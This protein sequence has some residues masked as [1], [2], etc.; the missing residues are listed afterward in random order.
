MDYS[1]RLGLKSR[2][3]WLKAVDSVRV[4]TFS[5]LFSLKRLKQAVIKL[6]RH[7][8]RKK[9]KE[10]MT[11]RTMW[12]MMILMITEIIMLQ[13]YFQD[14][15]PIMN[16]TSYFSLLHSF[17]PLNPGWFNDSFPS[18]RMQ[19]TWCCMVTIAGLKYCYSLCFG[20]RLLILWEARLH[21]RSP[22]NLRKPRCRKFKLPSGKVKW[23]KR[24]LATTSYF[25]YCRWGKRHAWI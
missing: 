2:I 23:R 24:C 4:L 22:S 13:L 1:L 3:F 7:D 25:W 15:P 21:L 17:L 10:M 19:P 20:L 18:K 6:R 9:K 14:H 8:G 12:M 16:H 11:V 5:C